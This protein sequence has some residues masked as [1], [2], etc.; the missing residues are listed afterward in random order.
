MDGRT[1]F[2]LSMAFFL[3]QCTRIGRLPF[4]R[5]TQKYNRPS[6]NFTNFAFCRK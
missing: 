2:R 5:F 3:V 6:A 4:V 1:K